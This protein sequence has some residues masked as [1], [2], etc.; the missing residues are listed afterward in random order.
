ML[1]CTQYLLSSMS[2]TYASDLNH[3][4]NARHKFKKSFSLGDEGLEVI[5]TSEAIY[6]YLEILLCKLSVLVQDLP[7]SQLP[8]FS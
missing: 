6:R 1:D 3:S 5:V 8:Y 7:S 2:S 4:L